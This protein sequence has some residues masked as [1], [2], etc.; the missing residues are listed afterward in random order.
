MMAKSTCVDGTGAEMCASAEDENVQDDVVEY[1]RRPGTYT[2]LVGEAILQVKQMCTHSAR[3]FLVNDTDAFK[4]ERCVVYDFMDLGTGEKR[5]AACMKEYRLNKAFSSS[6]YKEMVAVVQDTKGENLFRLVPLPEG[7]DTCDVGSESD[8]AL[9]DGECVR[10][11]LVHMRQFPQ[12]AILS[13]VVDRGELNASMVDELA[14]AVATSYEVAAV[15]TDTNIAQAFEWVVKDNLD[16]LAQFVEHGILD[17]G[18]VDELTRLTWA[19]FKHGQELMTRREQEGKVRFCHGDLHL[20]NIAVVD[21]KPTLFDCI[22]FNDKLAIGDVLYD[23]SFLLMDMAHHKLDKLANLLLNRILEVTADYGGL[24]LL[25]LFLATRATIRSKIACLTL[26]HCKKSDADHQQCLTTANRYLKYAISALRPTS[27]LLVAIGGLSG[28]GKS[29]IAREVAHSLPGPLGA[30]ILRSD[31]VR[32]QELNV[33]MTT[34]LGAEEYTA[35][36]LVAVYHSLAA[37]AMSLHESGVSVVL[38]ATYSKSVYRA[39]LDSLPVHGAVFI[40]VPLEIRKQRVSKRESD[41][42]DADVGLVA[43]LGSANDIPDQQLWQRVD[44]SGEISVVTSAVS[45][46]LGLP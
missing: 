13:A 12:E 26:E 2:A 27:P 35:E 15:R 11:Y 7:S 41:A 44:G 36:R 17:K 22:E 6:V 45:L 31:V 16:E 4:L 39:T 28:S 42:S 46:A 1:L 10:E 25:P 18:P 38:D 29:T 20:N 33:P 8:L 9:K 21:G 24:V 14:L 19:S 30:V 3:I 43:R 32:K 23:L 40:Q 5:K 34:R 37:R